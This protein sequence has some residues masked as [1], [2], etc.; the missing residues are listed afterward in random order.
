[1]KLFK[2]ETRNAS[3]LRLR[4]E[5]P[6]HLDETKKYSIGLVGF[7]YFNVNEYGFNISQKVYIKFERGQLY[8]EPGVYTVQQIEDLIL[9]K[10]VNEFGS[11]IINDTN[12]HLYFVRLNTEINKIE[13]KLPLDVVLDVSIARMMG[14]PPTVPQKGIYEANVFHEATT[15]PELM[16]QTL[17]ENKIIEIHCNLVEPAYV[18]HENNPHSHREAD[19]LYAFHPIIIKNDIMIS[20][21]P[22]M[23]LPLNKSIKSIQNIVIEIRNE[24]GEL[25]NVRDSNTIIYITINEDE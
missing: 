6:I 9:K 17:F 13:F 21:L 12:R 22:V 8:F 24:K 5:H 11:D 14:F 23:Y 4:L 18:S 15:D 19:I 2:L 3:A 20:P 1:M 7:F 16:Q 25:I 10:I